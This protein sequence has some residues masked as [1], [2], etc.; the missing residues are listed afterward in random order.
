LELSLNQKMWPLVIGLHF[1]TCSYLE[2]QISL[3]AQLDPSHSAIINTG[4]GNEQNGSQHEGAKDNDHFYSNPN[5]KVHLLR[6]NIY[7]YPHSSLS[8][9]GSSK[10]IIKILTSFPWI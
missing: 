4:E 1:G 6:T 3:A 8:K 5:E 9:S 10:T 2:E 7:W